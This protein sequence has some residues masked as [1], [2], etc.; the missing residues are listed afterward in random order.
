M[1]IVY[2]YA[3]TPAE[4]NCSE[5][6]CA[7]PARAIN[8]VAGHSA[9]LVWID[10]FSLN[11]PVAREACAAANLI[12][13][14][15]NLF[16]RVLQAIAYWQG[17]GKA[18]IA[19][20]DD[21]YDLLPE[22]IGA[23]HF[24]RRGMIPQLNGDGQITWRKLPFDPLVEFKRGLRLVHAAT[25]P[26]R[27]LAA[28]WQEYTDVRVLPNYLDL[29]KYV[30]VPPRPHEGII[31]GW[32]GSVSHFDSFAGSGIFQALAR[33]VA[34]R[35]NVRVMICGNDTRIFEHLPLPPERKIHHPFVPFARWP[36]VLATF[37]IGLAPLH[38]P[39]DQRR[40]W[41]KALEYMV[42][43]IPWVGTEGA[44]YHDL[45]AYGWLVPND[46][47]A[48]EHALLTLIDHLDEYKAQA[49]R[50]PYLQGL[51]L[52]V[53]VNVDHIL[54]TYEDI[55]QAAQHRPRRGR[56]VT[57]DNRQRTTASRR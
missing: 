7:I 51:M 2:V 39:Y 20:F 23:Y 37:D 42:M 49:A 43:K 47:T 11:R 41:I 4:W 19:D 54:A 29:E 15:R 1:N 50:Q 17:Q 5:W 6:R 57:M 9:R 34:A 40:S 36:H 55:I 44:P 16:G 35:P 10:D 56:Q 3:D 13:V 46:P 53:D 30:F 31:L 48:W 12:V 24:W 27:Q 33:V 38:G 21:A 14:Q 22:S 25:V 18:V 26:S 8:K 32:G 45:A 28:D 52:S